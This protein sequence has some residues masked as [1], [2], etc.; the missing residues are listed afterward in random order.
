M[1]NGVVVQKDPEKEEVINV[2]DSDNEDDLDAG[3]THVQVAGLCEQL[4]R[5][6]VISS[7]AVCKVTLVTM[8]DNSTS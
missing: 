5:L 7:H 3:I 1:F 6:I 4:E 8:G 2:D